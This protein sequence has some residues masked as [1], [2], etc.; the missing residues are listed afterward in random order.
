MYQINSIEEYLKVIEKYDFYSEKYFRG[1]KRQYDDIKPTIARK[2][3]YLENESKIYSDLLKTWPKHF[4]PLNN[5]L[6]NLSIIQHYDSPTRLIDLTTNPL[7]A[8]Y[9]AVEDIKCVDS[10]IVLLYIREGRDNSDKHTRLLSLL[11][12]EEDK[13]IESLKKRFEQIF[14]HVITEKEIL[15]YAKEPVFIKRSE[16]NKDSN[17][18][19]SAQE[20]TFFLCSNKVAGNVITEAIVGLD[21]IAPT[22]TVMIPY[23]YKAQIKADLDEKHRINEMKVY[24]EITSSATYIREKYANNKPTIEGKYEIIKEEDCSFGRVRRQS[25]D[26][27]LTDDLPILSMEEIVRAIVANKKNECDVIWTYMAKNNDDY[28]TKN[29]IIRGIWVNPYLDKRFWPISAKGADDEGFAWTYSNAYSIRS[30][31]NNRYVFDEE[32][33]LLVC[34][35]KGYDEL[36]I[37]FLKL[38]EAYTSMPLCEFRRKVESFGEKVQEC[39]STLGDL[40]LSRNEKFNEFLEH[41]HAFACDMKNLIGGA[42]QDRSSENYNALV[43]IDFESA[44]KSYE[45]IES[46]LPLWMEEMRLT[47]DDIS[48]IGLKKRNKP[49]LEYAQTISVSKDALNVYFQEKVEV[50]FNKKVRISGKTN[51][52]DNAKIMLNVLGLD[53]KY[54]ASTKATVR[55]GSFTFEVISKKGEGLNVGKYKGV[56]S[57]SIPS[58]QSKD[59][60]KAAG[61]EYEN[62]DG[63]Y[64]LRNGKNSIV[65]Y[66]FRFSIS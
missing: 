31:F 23:E 13:C 5:P 12:T 18:R 26:I 65:R 62:L 11:A 3:G 55:D 64:V 7:I 41:I 43:K 4:S 15:K 61:I 60:V 42:K 33:N 1:Q 49:S 37:I 66:G 16:S 48:K 22:M 28:A 47:D 51:L 52:F 2:R 24:P 10:A 63:Q 36:K 9:F 56:I 38:K 27:M 14:K 20:G 30:D 50:M 39:Y 59:F 34:C 8:L 44:E 17:E 45:A 25:V 21:S 54:Q 32:L 53:E 40:G 57:L 46:E 29:W 6:E 35:K 58:I 19:R